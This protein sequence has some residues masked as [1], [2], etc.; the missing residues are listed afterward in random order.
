MFKRVVFALVGLGFAFVLASPPKAEAQLHVG[1][2]IGAPVVVVPAYES[3][4]H[5]GYYYD[6]GYRYQR[7]YRGYR[8]YDHAYGGHDNWRN[9]R[10]H[11]D[12]NHHDRHHPDG[13]HR[14]WGHDRDHSDYNRNR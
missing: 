1:V 7:D 14:D 8:R 10:A 12:G 13:D 2:Q 9:D 6:H 4:Y 3:G 5:E 11:R